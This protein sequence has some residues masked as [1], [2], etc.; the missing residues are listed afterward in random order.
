M[1]P[2]KLPPVPWNPCPARAPRRGAPSTTTGPG[3]AVLCPPTSLV[4]VLTGCHPGMNHVK[5]DTAVH[6]ERTHLKTF[7][8][9]RHSLA[10]AFGRVLHKTQNSGFDF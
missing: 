9:W 1:L 3:P 5:P 10:Q 4:D 2:R 8:S 6:R 7:D